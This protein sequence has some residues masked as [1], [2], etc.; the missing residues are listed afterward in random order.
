MVTTRRSA[1]IIAQHN[2]DDSSSESGRDIASQ[3]RFRDLLVFE[4]RLKSNVEMHRCKK[5][6]LICNLP[7]LIAQIL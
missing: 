6:Q 1:Q 2:R 7:L 3:R 5:Q 4:E